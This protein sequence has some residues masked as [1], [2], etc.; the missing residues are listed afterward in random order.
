MNW[1]KAYGIQLKGKIGMGTLYLIGFVTLIGAMGTQLTSGLTPTRIPKTNGT[2][3]TP[4]FE[5][6]QSDKN[7]LQLYTFGFITSAP[8]VPQPTLP[9]QPTQPPGE[10]C[11]TQ[12]K[13]PT[14]TACTHGDSMICTTP[15]DIDSCVN[16]G[17]A[18]NPLGWYEPQYFCAYQKIVDEAKYNQKKS[19]PNCVEACIAKPVVYLYPL[20]PTLI[21][22][23]VTSPGRVY[24]SDP[25]Y[26]EG[27][28]K[29]V[30]AYP[31]GSLVYQN[32]SYHELYYE[33][34]VDKVN[35]PKDGIV[36]AKKDLKKKLTELTT[37]LGLRGIEQDEFLEYWLPELYKLDAPLVLFSIIDPVEKERI[38][39]VEINP[40]PDTFIAFL[41]YFKPLE[42]QPTNLKPLIIPEN[43]P[44]RIG[45]TAV[46]WGGTI[47]N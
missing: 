3:V 7:N 41:A 16:D 33:S 45:Y 10:T 15:N 8:T 35:P 43:P 38:D 22:V 37:R 17:G 32:K 9:P 30:L 34:D 24:V 13:P 21:D 18:P 25:E 31:D 46:E 44:K 19:D 28:W 39:H 11:Q 2:A 12:I 23:K 47:D 26:P 14:C 5:T 6:P 1:K 42:T 29:N 27:G 4:K 40:K 36:I 20:T